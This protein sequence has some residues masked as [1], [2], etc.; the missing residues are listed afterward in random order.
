[1][2]DH[3]LPAN[4]VRSLYPKAQLSLY[5][6]TL[7][8]LAAVELGEADAYLGDAISTDFMIGK[9]FQ[10]TL[11]IDHFPGRPRSVRVRPVQ[12]QPALAPAGRQGTGPHQ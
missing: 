8:G 11:K 3:Y 12:R 10:G 9:S 6:S 4:T 7:A 5:R 1:M 2:V